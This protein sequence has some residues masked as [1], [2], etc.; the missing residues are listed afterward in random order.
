MFGFLPAN[1]EMSAMQRTLHP[2]DR[3]RI[4]AFGI[5]R[6]C[7]Q[8]KVEL[9]LIHLHSF[10]RRHASMRQQYRMQ[11]FWFFW[12]VNELYTLPFIWTHADPCWT[13]LQK[14]RPG[15]R[16]REWFGSTSTAFYFHPL[17]WIKQAETSLNKWYSIQVF[18]ASSWYCKTWENLRIIACVNVSM[19]LW[20]KEYHKRIV[21]AA[22]KSGWQGGKHL[23]LTAEWTREFCMGLM[24][25]WLK[26][27]VAL[28]HTEGQWSS[29]NGCM[30]AK[31][32]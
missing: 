29:A 9:L 15:E 18:K 10:S 7:L 14:G 28:R 27:C 24:H 31:W 16:T 11:S 13:D 32:I 3:Q 19:P 12:N 4:K 8:H 5:L 30:C 22:G 1:R 21:S 2:R 17:S 6:G 26:A 20:A 25:C 23:A